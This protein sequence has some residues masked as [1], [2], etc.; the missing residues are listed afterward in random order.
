MTCHEDSRHGLEDGDFVTF[1]E[2]EGMCELNGAEAR[3]VTVINPYSFSVG[4]TSAFHEYSGTKG[5]FNQIKKPSTRSFQPLKDLLH[6]PKV[7]GH[8]R[9]LFVHVSMGAV[10]LN[11]RVPLRFWPTGSASP[12]RCTASTMACLG[13]WRRPGVSPRPTVARC[14]RVSAAC[15]SKSLCLHCVV[16]PPLHTGRGAHHCPEQGVRRVDGGRGYPPGG[17]AHQPLHL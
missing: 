6:K 4:D 16:P 3:P 17:S 9:A 12:T 10:A 1:E 7:R 11:H 14:H 8:A 13:S 5:Y 2:V 15:T